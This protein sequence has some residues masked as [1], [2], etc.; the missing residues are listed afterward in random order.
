MTRHTI[1]AVTAIILCA[2]ALA[3]KPQIQW[4]PEYDFSGVST[5]QWREP[6]EASLADSDPFLHSRIINAINYEL[7]EFGLTEV[8][9]EP[10]V[11]ITYHSST[12][13]D[14]RITSTSVGYGFGSYGRGSWGYYGYGFGG[15]VATT[16]RATEVE[17]GTLMVD[18]VDSASN[19]L[20]WRG[21]IDDIVL[22]DNPEKTQRNVVS[23]IEKMAKQYRKLR[24]REAGR[25]R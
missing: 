10:D 18:V 11:F 15:P 23:A 13:T 12:Q 21:S 14:V 6:P 24:A 1:A 7:T 20:V 5:F 16:S 25:R 8:S 3:A 19:E 4:D 22:S 17:R 2:P 9:A